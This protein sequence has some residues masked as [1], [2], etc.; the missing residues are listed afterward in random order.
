MNLNV[1]QKPH[2]GRTSLVLADAETR[3]EAQ[4]SGK[5]MASTAMCDVEAWR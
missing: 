3:D 1:F 4:A 5:W 2:K